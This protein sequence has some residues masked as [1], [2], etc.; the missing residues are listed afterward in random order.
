MRSRSLT[1]H[2]LTDRG[3]RTPELDAAAAEMLGVVTLYASGEP[4]DVALAADILDEVASKVGADARVVGG[5][6]SVCA[7]LLV[8]LEFDAGIPR[9]EALR[10]VGELI[11]YAQLDR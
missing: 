9:S 1:E 11:A 5:L 8:V 3:W 4:R 7:A 6:V 2:G 10:R